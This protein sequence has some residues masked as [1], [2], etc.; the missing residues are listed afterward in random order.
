[1]N[2]DIQIAADA[3]FGQ[4]YVMHAEPG[5]RAP[6]NTA[7][8]PNA[9]AAQLSTRRT[10]YGL[11][12]TYWYAI[13]FKLPSSWTQPDW[14]TLTTLG[15]PTLSSGPIDIAIWPVKGVLNYTLQM[16]SGL[17]RKDAAGS[18]RGSVSTRTAIAPVTLGKWVEM[19]LRIRWATNNTGLVDVYERLEGQTSWRHAVSKRRLPTA[20]YG[21]TP[22]GT[23]NANGTDPDGTK[24]SVLDKIGLYFG[25]W[26]S[27]TT[28]FPARSVS[29]T[30][31]TRA[32][33]FAAAAATLR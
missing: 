9:A 18:Y 15:Y 20:Q 12:N 8:P 22:Y 31:L 23:V 30:G 21:T 3:H 13:G 24:H 28:S 32:S 19:V 5:S 25:Y 29:E 6:Y 4:V 16:N 27:A 7:A 33:D 14:V 17:L 11:G 2:N 26:N 1:M 10:S